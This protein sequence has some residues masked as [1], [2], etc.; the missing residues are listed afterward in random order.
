[1][2]ILSIPEILL[3][4]KSGLELN[5][6]E[7]QY[8]VA[9]VGN[10]TIDASQIGA[11]LMAVC[12]R[13][14][15]SRE[16]VT[17][18][19]AMLNGGA[20]QTWDPTWTV[21]DKHSTGGI[22]DKV[23]FP[24]FAA[25][26]AFDL[27]VPSITGRGLGHT[28]G[29]ADKLESIPGY[30]IHLSPAL[31]ERTLRDVGA[32][33]TCQGGNIAPV[34]KVLYATRDITSTVNDKSLITASIMSKKL[35]EGISSLVLDVKTGG[36]SVIGTYENAEQLARIMV[37]VGNGMG[38]KTTAVISE[39]DTPI[40]YM[41]G[42]SLEIIESLECLKGNG[43][44]DLEK[45]T[46]VLGAVLLESVGIAKDLAQGEQMVIEK[47][48]NGSALDKFLQILSSHAV[49]KDIIQ[50]LREGR[51]SEVFDQPQHVDKILAECTG[52]IA[53]VDALALGK[54][55]VLLGGGRQFPGD[56]IEMAVGMVLKRTKGESVEEGDVLLEIHHNGRL[57]QDIR[58]RIQGAFV[59][60]GQGCTAIK[61]VVSLVRFGV[62]T[63]QY[64]KEEGS[65]EGDD[66]GYHTES[67]ESKRRKL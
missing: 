56:K 41:I 2:T 48:R 28:G 40:G 7:I 62:P 18:T 57:S 31:M 44:A 65:G 9:C 12:C 24:L 13:G 4:K 35:S 32:Y 8:F 23:S 33:I 54:A 53:S 16:T 36:G 60:G 25:L 43:P 30:Q 27:K 10:K 20:I 66:N 45:I 50:L 61:R 38:V 67:P 26:A 47:L 5:D 64:E 37:D 59:V 55:C 21:V 52:H 39:M 29:T 3:K 51:Y 19:K 17:L 63:L 46:A 58:E 34:D 1:M 49:S 42:N 6:A 11:F 15:S 14:F 22:G